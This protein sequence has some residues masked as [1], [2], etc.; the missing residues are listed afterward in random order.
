MNSVQ[1]RLFR[2]FVNG[3]GD[4]TDRAAVDRLIRFVDVQVTLMPPKV[5]LAMEFVLNAQGEI[6]YAALSREASTR[7]GE[8]I[9]Q[10]ALRQR[11]SRGVRTLEEAVRRRARA[12][13]RGEPD[14]RE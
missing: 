3:G 6:S 7:E 1:R 12:L 5:K 13:A 4:I 8:P 10:A 14:A 11:V 9:S 2:V